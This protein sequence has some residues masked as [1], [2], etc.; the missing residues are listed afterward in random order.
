MVEPGRCHVMVEWLGLPRGS[1]VVGMDFPTRLW[2][3]HYLSEEVFALVLRA[4]LAILI[5]Q[6][7]R[8]VFVASGH[9][10]VN[11]KATIDR[12]C[13]ELQNT[14]PARLDHDLTICREALETGLAGHADIVE[15]SLLMHYQAGAVDLAALP[16]REVP[17]RYQD[18]SVVDGAGFTIGLA[19]PFTADGQAIMLEDHLEIRPERRGQIEKFLREGK[20]ASGPWYVLPDEFLVSGK[21]LIRNLRVGRELVRSLGGTPSSAGVLADLFGHNSQMP[22]LFKGFG[23]TGILLRRGLNL[24]RHRHLIRRGAVGTEMPAYRFGRFGYSRQ[25]GAVIRQSPHGALAK[26]LP[27]VAGRVRWIRVFPAMGVGKFHL[28]GTPPRRFLLASP[29]GPQTA[30]HP[31]NPFS[32]AEHPCLISNAPPENQTRPV[33]WNGRALLAGKRGSLARSPEP[34]VHQPKN[35]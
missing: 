20:R 3:S 19:G 33:F 4:E 25:H 28:A 5:G 2:N 35:R 1:Y 14:T 30:A 24:I 32:T 26:Q 23:A 18:Y 11:Q 31:E 15:T 12:L 27:L 16:P 9:G 21:S 17:I 7:Y 29:T 8:C 6:G 22:Q 10:A 13:I 34:T